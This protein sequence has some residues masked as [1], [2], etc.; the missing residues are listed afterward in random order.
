M[1]EM[2][3]RQLVR[4][5]VGAGALGILV[6][7]WAG[8][9]SSDSPSST[10]SSDRK[11]ETWSFQLGWLHGVEWAGTYLAAERG[12]HREEGL[13]LN[14]VPGGPQV[15]AE[16]RIASGRAKAGIV[17]GGGVATADKDGAGLKILASKLQKSP[18]GFVTKQDSGITSVDDL[19]GKRFGVA[20]NS[21]VSAKTY[22]KNSGVDASKVKFV[23]VQTNYSPLTNGDVDAFYT[24][25]TEISPLADAG[26]KTRFIFET[27]ASD[28]VDMSDLYGA[29]EKVIAENRDQLVGLLRAEVRGWQDFVDDPAAGVKLAV[30]KYGKALGLKQQEQAYQAK[31]YV[32]LI[33]D[34]PIVKQKGLLWT[35]DE[36]KTGIIAASKATGA[37]LSTDV[38]DDSILRD[39]YGGKTRL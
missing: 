20:T 29:T 36:V 32:D 24:Y 31:A 26:V 33:T 10:S 13:K 16:P 4:A 19:V 30:E 12:Y 8:C 11:L 5:G 6:P 1:S 35:S 21:V 15:N 9:G 14:L 38:F 18:I 28:D 7:A 27:D 2:T 22:L 25:Y 34:A 39:A 37:P 23:P 3:R 17:Y